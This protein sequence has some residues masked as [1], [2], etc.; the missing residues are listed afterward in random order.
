VC[1][2]VCVCV[3]DQPILP[4]GDDAYDD[5]RH[6]HPSIDRDPQYAW[7]RGRGGGACVRW[8]DVEEEGGRI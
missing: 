2:C 7:G 3:C 1:V 4:M 5:D 8:H 6:K